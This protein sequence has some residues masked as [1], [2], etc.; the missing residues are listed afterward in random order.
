ME[1]PSLLLGW[2]LE[3]AVPPGRPFAASRRGNRFTDVR[4]A[5]RYRRDGHLLTFAPT[6]AGK[7]VRVIIPNLLHY[8]GPVITVDPKG[9]NFA[10]TARYR[11][12]VLGQRIFLLDPFEAVS[13]ET[14]DRV[15]VERGTLNPLDLLAELKGHIEPQLTMLASMFAPDDREGDDFWHQEALKLLA[16]VIGATVDRAQAEGR[17]PQFQAMIDQLFG[18]DVVY[19]LAVLLDTFKGL[20]K[21]SYRA[22][23]AFLQKAEKEKSGVT[24]TVHSYLTPFLSNRINQYL[25]SSTIRPGMILGDDDYT[26]YI[27][28]PP[29]KLISH[30]ILLRIWVST[31]LLT[32][33]EREDK[34]LRRT[35][36]LLDECA[37]LGRLEALTKAVTLLRGYGLQVWMF[38]QDIG[39][40][41]N[42]YGGDHA[43]VINNCE[44]FQAFGMT[45]FSAAEPVA[46]ITGRF[47]PLDLVQIDKTQQLLSLATDTPRVMRLMNYREDP[48]FAGR[49]DENPLFRRQ[50]TRER[51]R[52]PFPPNALR[53]HI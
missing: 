16:G 11:R 50:G 2:P 27:V 19:S 53:I 43:T 49:Y 20:G 17:P 30:A 6:G 39:Q 48:L 51:L 3:P 40:L 4:A 25:D 32:I 31:L 14:L 24:S 7:G 18:D 37:Q 42:L 12:E 41:L 23:A 29:S 34:P 22:I 44:V 46:E 1:E 13:Q 21:F 26:I 47:E 8:S 15:G 52:T 28:I 33:M 38:F 36:F 5:T 9:E 35:L 10:V 45:R